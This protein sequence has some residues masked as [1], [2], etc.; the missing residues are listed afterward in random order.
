MFCEKPVELRG[1][2]LPV[3]LTECTGAAEFN[4][5]VPQFHHHV[6][7]GEAF[8]DVVGRVEFTARVERGAAAFDHLRGKRDVGG[9]HQIVG[10]HFLRD[11]VV[12]DIEPG[13]YL[14]GA[15][16]W[17]GWHTQRLVG[18]QRGQGMGPLGSPEQNFLD[19]ARTGVGVDPDAHAAGAVIDWHCTLSK[20]DGSCQRFS[21][22]KVELAEGE[23]MEAAPVLEEVLEAHGGLERWHALEVIHASLSSGGLAFASHCQP[24]ALRDVRVA[25]YPHVPR[26]ELH[27]FCHPGW[28]GCWTPDAVEIR[29]EE[30]RLVTYRQHPRASFDRLVRQFC[31]DRLDI[32][33][34]AGYALWNYLSFPFILTQAEVRVVSRGDAHG[35][36]LDAV[37]PVATPTHSPRQSFLIDGEARLVRHDYTADVIGSWATA[38]NL[39]L[40]SRVA[41]GLR[42]YTRRKVYPRWMGGKAVLPFPTLVWIELDDLDVRLAPSGTCA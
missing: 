5:T 28:T 24:Y 32:L 26:V 13:R 10:L 3:C 38:A 7:H 6:A 9:D 37:F 16:E 20:P 31:W 4:A 29:N 27:D 12:R 40:A 21:E 17:G 1:K 2:R 39:C 33:Y 8:P 22:L 19:D 41:G 11:T 15:D 23:C 35:R 42:F 18:D 25:V 30:G 14:Q 36:W 34:F